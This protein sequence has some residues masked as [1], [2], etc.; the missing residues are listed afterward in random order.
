MGFV[1]FFF[2]GAYL[3]EVLPQE[4]GVSRH[5]L[6]PLIEFYNFISCKNKRSYSQPEK[7]KELRIYMG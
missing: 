4:Y 2:L 5:P 1:V 3:M 7:D 6:F